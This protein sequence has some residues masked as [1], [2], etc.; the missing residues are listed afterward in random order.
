MTESDYNNNHIYVKGK[1]GLVGS[2]EIFCEF[3]L[4][5]ALSPP[6]SQLTDMFF[7]LE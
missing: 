6:Q 4:Y 3:R 7:F 5:F 1:L 2:A